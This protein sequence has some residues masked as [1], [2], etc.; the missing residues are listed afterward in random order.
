MS[1][2]YWMAQDDP[3]K[4]DAFLKLPLWEYWTIVDNKLSLFEKQ[5]MSSVKK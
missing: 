1:Q 5:K 2:V 4:I 3:N